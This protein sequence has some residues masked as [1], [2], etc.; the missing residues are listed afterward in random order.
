MFLLSLATNAVD[1]TL[2]A[3]FASA[4]S[5]VSYGG[6][7]N[8][9]VQQSQISTYL[10]VLFFRSAATIGAILM[11][12]YADAF[13]QSRAVNFGSFVANTMAG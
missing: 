13:P 8:L 9:G 6:G 10:P 5:L 1:S 12:Y 7:S 2:F 4:V 3:G 11:T